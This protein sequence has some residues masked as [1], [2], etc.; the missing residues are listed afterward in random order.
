MQ[1]GRAIYPGECIGITAPSSPAEL[2][3]T[4][5]AVRFLESLGY[6]V[7]LGWTALARK[8][9]LA[10]SDRLRA[11][12]LNAFFADESVAA[13][14]C[15]R[16]GYGAARLLPA[17]DY[18]M[19]ARHPKLFIGYSDITALHTALYQRSSL[20]TIHGPV[21]VQLPDAAA[22]TRSMFC[23]G[24]RG[25]LGGEVKLPPENTLVPFVTG[26][27]QG[28]LVGGN[29]AVLASLVGT[30]YELD[31]SG[32]ILF[33]EEIGEAPYRIDRLLNQLWQSGLLGR[34][35]GLIFGDFTDC[36]GDSGCGVDEVIRYYAN[37]CAK[38]TASGLPAGHGM[39]NMF[40][41]FGVMTVLDCTSETV[42]LK[43]AEE[44]IIR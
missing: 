11:A 15:L 12:E 7:R 2:P 21:A 29:L 19:I 13:I 32:C 35:G 17:L 33:L 9:F 40:L 18:A 41:P 44:Y 31:A 42:S 27:A 23:A 8:G 6:I 3:T 22:Y 14:L 38:P 25:T 43:I 20:V 4:W 30:P 5:A 10:G 28:R 26:Q 1:R 34:I 39:Y 24:L 37:L 16:G 36:N